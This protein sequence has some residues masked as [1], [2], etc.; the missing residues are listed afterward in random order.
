MKK[1]T[2]KLTIEGRNTEFWKDAQEVKSLVE[3]ALSSYGLDSNNGM[4]VDLISTEDSSEELYH[5]Y[6]FHAIRQDQSRNKIHYDG[7]VSMNNKIIGYDGFK[8]MK[9]MID[10]EHH[11]TLIV[12]NVEYIGI[13]PMC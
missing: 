6:F 7:M 5:N 2:F 13:G 3:D 8:R 12:C 4:H 10:P 11:D 9:H 1:Y